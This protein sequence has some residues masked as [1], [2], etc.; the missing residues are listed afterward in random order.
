MTNNSV[1]CA[2]WL[3]FYGDLSYWHAGADV[4]G[5][6]GANVQNVVWREIENA[7]LMNVEDAPPNHPSL[8]K[9]LDRMM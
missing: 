3:K 8:D 9:F 6:V 7:M 5:I 1:Y 4:V 2:V